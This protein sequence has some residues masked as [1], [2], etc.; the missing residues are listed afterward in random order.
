MLLAIDI[1]NTLT[2]LALFEG[3]LIRK[4]AVFSTKDFS[5]GPAGLIR[6]FLSGEIADF[7]I[8]SLVVAPLGEVLEEAFFSLG[9]AHRVLLQGSRG[10]IKDAVKDISE[11]GSDIMA[12]VRGALLL[13]N[14]PY[15]IADLGTA[16]KYI[17]VDGENTFA[18]MAIDSGLGVSSRALGASASALGEVAYE[19]PKSPLGRDT[20][21]C[22]NA[23]FLYGRKYEIEGFCRD[24][25][26]ILGSEPRKILTG[27]NAVYLKGILG[28]FE[29]LPDLSLYG[30]LSIASEERNGL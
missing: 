13:G 22:M 8:V 27:G 4:K 1:G 16:D 12:D 9:T 6:G 23:G 20:S 7:A 24:Y 21:E 29:Y 28:G 18:G 2:K 14:G 30:L 17:L 19:L 3:S 25:A 15:F 11:V 5:G 10:I 26:A